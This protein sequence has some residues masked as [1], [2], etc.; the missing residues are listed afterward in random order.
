MIISL[1]F[2]N[3]CLKGSKGYV[4]IEKELFKRMIT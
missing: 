1:E 4:L 2:L 3:L